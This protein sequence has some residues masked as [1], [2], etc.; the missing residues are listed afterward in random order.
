MTENQKG[1]FHLFLALAAGA[2]VLTSKSRARH[3][4]LGCMAG[5]HM[6]L[7]AEHFTDTEGNASDQLTRARSAGF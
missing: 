6:V 3:L 1:I 5:W 7:A 4:L 2:E